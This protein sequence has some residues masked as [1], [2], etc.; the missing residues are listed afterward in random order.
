MRE[1]KKEKGSHLYQLSLTGRQLGL[2][3]TALILIICLTFV[4]GYL[5]GGAGR[6]TL[7]SREEKVEELVMAPPQRG[8]APTQEEETPSREELTFYETLLEEKPAPGMKGKP[9]SPGEE[10]GASAA[11]SPRGEAPEER[12]PPAR[13]KPEA[14]TPKVA[15]EP[16]RPKAPQGD[17][18]YTVQVSSL[19]SFS[20][21]EALR[22]RLAKRGY[23]A[24][25]EKVNL[26]DKGLFHRV[27]V[28]SFKTR[29]GAL[30]VA[31][32][33]EERENIKGAMVARR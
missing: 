13:V 4:L 2:T 20:R 15:A 6:E 5:V 26:G 10:A 24:Y 30:R 33:I 9:K 14:P 1:E 21:A 11:I 3:L 22:A 25:V 18:L 7:E 27:R 19:R 28:G 29:A 23:E 12:K 17:G 31:R 16:S 32:R 8:N